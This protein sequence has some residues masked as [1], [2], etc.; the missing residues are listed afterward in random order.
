MNHKKSSRIFAFSVV[1][2]LANSAVISMEENTPPYPPLPFSAPS[3]PARQ[4]QKPKTVKPTDFRLRLELVPVPGTSKSALMH[5]KEQAAQDPAVALMD[6]APEESIPL[7]QPVAGFIPLGQHQDSQFDDA[8]SAAAVAQLETDIMQVSILPALENLI[9]H[10]WTGKQA[11]RLAIN[12]DLLGI[13][14]QLKTGKPKEASETTKT[15]LVR[16]NTSEATDGPI[17]EFSRLALYSVQAILHL[18]AGTPYEALNNFLELRQLGISWCPTRFLDDL[19]GGTGHLYRYLTDFVS[20]DTALPIWA[21]DERIQKLFQGHARFAADQHERE[22]I[23][24]CLGGLGDFPGAEGPLTFNHTLYVLGKMQL[25]AGQIKALYASID[26]S[27]FLDPEAGL[28]LDAGQNTL[29]KIAGYRFEGLFSYRNAATNAFLGEALLGKSSLVDSD[30]ADRVRHLSEA[31]DHY[32]AAIDLIEPKNTTGAEM[33]R[34]SFDSSMHIIRSYALLSD[35]VL[36]VA[37][38]SAKLAVFKETLAHLTSPLDMPHINRFQIDA[39]LDEEL[40]RL[41][42]P[43]PPPA[44]VEATSPRVAKTRANKR[45]RDDEESGRAEEYESSDEDG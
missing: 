22:E 8:T 15:L 16:V 5:P 19:L 25:K 4:P 11:P 27:S 17:D 40:A 32:I 9:G 35:G 38:K 7:S 2:L 45:P 26:S 44:A 13:V 31:L 30:T 41:I 10:T 18:L 24:K 14:Q 3:T 43:P 36:P 6:A 42:P 23:V 34:H 28:L 12:D 1:T 21:G 33:I 39:V 20:S 37:E 29:R